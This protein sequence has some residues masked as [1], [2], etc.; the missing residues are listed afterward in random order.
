MI[1]RWLFRITARRPCRLI[2]IGPRQDRPYLERYYLGRLLGWTVYLH[3]FLG[4]DDARGPHDHPWRRAFS[5]VLCGGYVE[6]RVVHLDPINGF[7]VQA[8]QLTAGSV[9]LI[10]ERTFHRIVHVE[11]GTW[12][13]F[14]HR[15][16]VK[17]WGFAEPLEGDGGTLQGIL[18]HQP[19]AGVSVLDTPWW[20]TAPRGENAGREAL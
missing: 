16:V 1:A 3:R 5:V 19:L 8:G 9:N 6:V 10:G 18:Y 2:K 20:V 17:G 14:A 13:L 7:C 15:R 12:T 4:P 11:P